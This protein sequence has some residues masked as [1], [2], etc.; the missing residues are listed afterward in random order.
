M[1]GHGMPTSPVLHRQAFEPFD[2][3]R[4]Q[5]AHAYVAVVI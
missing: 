5:D 1:D 4:T 3:I 2:C